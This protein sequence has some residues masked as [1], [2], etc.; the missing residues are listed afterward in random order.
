MQSR[1]SNI[2][3]NSVTLVKYFLKCSHVGQIFPEIQSRWSN[4]Y[5]NSVT[6]VKYFLKCS[7]VGL[8]FFVIQSGWSNNSCNATLFA[9][10]KLANLHC[11]FELISQWEWKTRWKIEKKLY[12]S[13]WQNV[14]HDSNAS[15]PLILI[16]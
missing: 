13:W 2:Y 14:L 16:T 11:F 1:W 12:Y 6:M 10:F 9:K 15:K 8:S 7:H 3:W 5:W 4:I